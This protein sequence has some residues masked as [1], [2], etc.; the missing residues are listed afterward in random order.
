[1]KMKLLVGWSIFVND[2]HCIDRGQKRYADMIDADRVPPKNLRGNKGQVYQSQS[3]VT[4]KKES[5]EK[6]GKWVDGYE[7][8]PYAILESASHQAVGGVYR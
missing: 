5:Q 6:A 3:R 7:H 8:R 2:Q 1:M 4:L